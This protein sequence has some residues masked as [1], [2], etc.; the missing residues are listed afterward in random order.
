L[1]KVDRVVVLTVLPIS[2]PTRRAAAVCL[3]VAIAA[4]RIGA[5]TL[6]LG[7]EPGKSTRA[8][9]DR[10][11]GQPLRASGTAIEYAPRGGSGPIVVTLQSDGATIDRIEVHMAEPVRR[12]AL[13]PTLNLPGTADGSRAANGRLVEFYGSPNLLVLTYQG[14]D[15]ASGIAS[16]GY[17]SDAPFAQATQGLSLSNRA[18]APSNAVS[19]SNA[20][21]APVI[22]QFNPN[23]CRDVYTAS[24][25]ESR[26]ARDSKNAA[27]RQEILA[28][29]IAAQKGD[30]VSA[31]SLFDAYQQKYRGPGERR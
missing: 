20:A 9:A 21:D 30:C 23:S 15:V 24:S 6:L 11:L 26:Q 27:R 22:M 18:S 5:V 25:A 19:L 8:D 14:A 1:E 2:K 7:L 12:D 17:Y 13:A 28:V 4:A 3:A 10:V 16:V 31:R 29:M